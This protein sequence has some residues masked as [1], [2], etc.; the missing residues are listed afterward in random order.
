MKVSFCRDYTYFHLGL[1]VGDIV[2]AFVVTFN[3]GF[4][5]IEWVV[6]ESK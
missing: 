6:K 4:W 3:L 5:A 2:G 1:S